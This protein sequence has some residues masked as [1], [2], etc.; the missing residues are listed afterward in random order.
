M[1]LLVVQG[2]VLLV[3]FGFFPAGLDCSPGALATPVALLLV[4]VALS[5]A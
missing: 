4:S 3:W 5:V 1:I 2:A